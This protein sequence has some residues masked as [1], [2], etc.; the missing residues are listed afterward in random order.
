MIARR[1][2]SPE[3]FVFGP[4]FEGALNDARGLL[5][6]LSFSPSS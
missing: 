6:R 4:S 1:P 5:D 2:G 3:V